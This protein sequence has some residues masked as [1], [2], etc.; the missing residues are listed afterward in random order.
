VLD[1][2]R[3]YGFSVAGLNPAIRRQLGIGSDWNGVV[4]TYVAPRSA[5]MDRGLRPGLVISAVGT[6]DIDGLQDFDQEVKK[7][8]DRKPILL[9]V[10]D[11]QNNSQATLAIPP[12]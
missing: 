3:S 7:A 6:R 9:L 4:V 11:P 2:V 12:R 5:A 8:G 1:L 10:L